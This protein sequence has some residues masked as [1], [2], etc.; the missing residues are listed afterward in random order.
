M[1]RDSNG[2]YN[3]TCSSTEP[4]DVLYRRALLWRIDRN[5]NRATAGGTGAYMYSWYSN[6][7]LTVPIGQFTA[8]AINLP[9]GTF[10]VKVTD[11]NLCEASASV[12]VS[13]PA[14]AL[15][16]TPPRSM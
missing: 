5:S 15:A 13:Q 9:A 2:Q 16:V 11:A 14:A 7:A 10:W 12:A 6:A 4:D 8:T 1:H 3:R